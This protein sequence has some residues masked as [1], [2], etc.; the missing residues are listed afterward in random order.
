M[1]KTEIQSLF[2]RVKPG[3]ID[4]QR[5]SICEIPDTDLEF[6]WKTI[7]EVQNVNVAKSYS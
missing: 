2:A 7:K 1:A 5:Q 3:M 4:P 6:Y